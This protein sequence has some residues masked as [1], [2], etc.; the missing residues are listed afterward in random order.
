LNSFFLFFVKLSVPYCHSKFLNF[1]S[2]FFKKTFSW[3]FSLSYLCFSK[4]FFNFF[5]V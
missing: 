1:F 3:K 5:D 4:T 2:I